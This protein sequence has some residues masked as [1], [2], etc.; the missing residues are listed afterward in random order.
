M[1]YSATVDTTMADYRK[2]KPSPSRLLAGFGAVRPIHKPEDYRLV[3]SDMEQAMAEEVT[4]KTQTQKRKSRIPKF[5]SYAEEAEFW[6]TQDIR[7]YDEF[8]PVK[9]GV[10]N[11]LI[12]IL[13]LEMPLDPK[14][15]D[16]LFKHAQQQRMDMDSVVR[17]WTLENMAELEKPEAACSEEKDS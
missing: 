17:R 4:N 11:P 10:A 8:E 7:E 15:I 1:T 12:H 14:I 6:D 13:R 3:R 5:K 2:R 9:L 16:K